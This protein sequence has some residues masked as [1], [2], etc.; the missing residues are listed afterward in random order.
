MLYFETSAKN[1]IGVNN[2]MYSCISKLPFFEP[3]QVDKEVLI[4]ELANSNSKNI[5]GGML[6]INNN[7]QNKVVDNAENSTHIILNK[8]NTEQKKKKKC[9]C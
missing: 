1:S 5:E 6:E 8:I 9:G 2:M 4:K 7:Q 3:F